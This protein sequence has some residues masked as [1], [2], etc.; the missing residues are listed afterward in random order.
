MVAMHGRESLVSLR[1]KFMSGDYNF[2]LKSIESGEETKIEKFSE[3]Q[4]HV[5][6]DKG[7]EVLYDYTSEKIAKLRDVWDQNPSVNIIYSWKYQNLEICIKANENNEIATPELLCW[8]EDDS[9]NRYCYVLALWD[10]TKEGWELRFI[11]SRPF[12]VFEEKYSLELDKVWQGLYVCQ[13]IL[14]ALYEG[15]RYV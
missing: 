8:E 3:V 1:E 9:H 14:D 11:G 13:K 15:T 7:F 5:L 4:K 2:F 6:E 12:E 10:K